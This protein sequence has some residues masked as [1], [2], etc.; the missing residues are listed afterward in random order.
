LKCADATR[1]HVRSA[2]QIAGLLF[3][4]GIASSD[5]VDSMRSGCSSVPRTSFPLLDFPFSRTRAALLAVRAVAVTSDRVLVASWKRRGRVYSA[6]RD[7]GTS[8]PHNH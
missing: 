3:I 4:A 5:A 1:F 8:K 7:A 6:W 2:H